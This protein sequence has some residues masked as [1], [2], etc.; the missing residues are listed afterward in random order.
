MEAPLL[1]NGMGYASLL[2][3]KM[4]CECIG[5]AFGA[6]FSHDE[7][8]RRCKMHKTADDY[9]VDDRSLNITEPKRG[10][11]TTHCESPGCETIARYGAYKPAVRCFHH[12]IEGDKNLFYTACIAT[13]DC[14]TLPSYGPAG[15][16]KL[17][18]FRHRCMG[19]IS[20]GTKTCMAK[21]CSDT[22]F[23]GISK[24]N[25]CGK[26]KG[27]EDIDQREEKCSMCGLCGHLDEQSRCRDCNPE[28][29]ERK[30]KEKQLQVQRWL[31]QNHTTKYTLT[32]RRV[33]VYGLGCIRQRPDFLYDFPTHV[34]ILEVD[35]DQHKKR[36]VCDETRMINIA[37]ILMRKTL[38]IRY[39]PDEYHRNGLKMTCQHAERMLVI[40][41]WLTEFE[42]IE[43]VTH[44]V[45]C[46]YLFFDN[47][48]KQNV[49]VVEIQQ[50]YL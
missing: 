6:C 9:L 14:T 12:K 11:P 46:V 13:V 35:E 40:R 45:S 37:Q 50:M 43:N 4:G 23:F 25:F 41:R 5:C 17:R 36:S 24:A 2:N 16:Q 1:K 18:C 32:D 8:P 33:F 29:F 21:L 30:I 48:D 42:S 3:R 31:D 20:L 49:P 7:I 27:Y 34:V 15:G 22:P 47:F 10:N 39:N 26:H 44:M 19:D 28:T 38:F